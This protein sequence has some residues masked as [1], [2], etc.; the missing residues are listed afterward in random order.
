MRLAL[1]LSCNLTEIRTYTA[2]KKKKKSMP[3]VVASSKIY[4]NVWTYLY[5]YKS[6][7]LLYAGDKW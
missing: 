4:L 2:K 6:N 7:F 5:W 1:L 3:G